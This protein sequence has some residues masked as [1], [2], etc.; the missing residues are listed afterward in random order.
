MFPSMFLRAI[1]L[2][3]F[4][5]LTFGETIPVTGLKQPVEILTDTWGVPHIYARNTGDAFFA[6]PT[7]RTNLLLDG[8]DPSAAPGDTLTIT[9]S[10][11][12]STASVSDPS[13]GPPHT[14]VIQ[15]RA[16]G[17]RSIV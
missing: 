10:G 6:S 17:H 13:L 12:A 9:T 15:C 5:G 2:L 11:P 8:G 4:A 3:A 14:R 16:Q 1:S 7:L